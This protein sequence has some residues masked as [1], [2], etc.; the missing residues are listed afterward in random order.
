MS[1]APSFVQL[2]AAPAP[3]THSAA[4]VRATGAGRVGVSSVEGATHSVL[5]R[6][7]HVCDL[8][9]QGSLAAQRVGVLAA[10]GRKTRSVAHQCESLL[11][12]PT[13]PTTHLTIIISGASS[14]GWK[15]LA[16]RGKRDE[17][18]R[19]EGELDEAHC[20]EVCGVR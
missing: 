17:R 10:R 18:E 7:E 12:L 9:H 20:V 13:A 1:E 2:T 11:R 16:Q 8:R 4:I 5:S 6:N 14:S 3:P 19:C 15:S